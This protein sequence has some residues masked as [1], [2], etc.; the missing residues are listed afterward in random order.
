MRSNED[1]GNL[2]VGHGHDAR[3][4]NDSAAAASDAQPVADLGASATPVSARVSTTA[5]LGVCALLFVAPFDGLQP[6]FEFPGQRVTSVEAALA[7]VLS[8]WVATLVWTRTTPIWRTSLSLPW[9]VLLVAMFVAALAAPAH[10]T[11]AV[12]MVGR[13]GVGFCVFLLT[14]NGVTTPARLRGVLAAAAA[15]GAFISV[16]VALE[17]L[18]V[19]VVTQW[20]QRFREHVTVIGSQVRAG[21]PFQYP[22]IASMY[23]EILFALALPLL[24]MT[25]D[26]GRRSLALILFLFLVLALLA[27][28]IGLTF[29]RAGLLTIASSLAIVGLLRYSRQGFDAGVTAIAAL[30]VAIAVQFLAT[31]PVESVM[32]RMTTEAQQSWYRAVIEPPS[33]IAMRT[34]AVASVPVQVTNAGRS[35]WDPAAGEPFLLSYH[36]LALDDERVVDFEGVRTPFP[37]VVAPG[38][39]VAVHARV[40][41]PNVPGRYRLLWDVVIERRLWFSMAPDAELSFSTV[42]VSGPAVGPPPV[43][44]VA[45]LPRVTPQPGRLTLWRAG[46]RMLIDHPLLGVG[47][48]NFHLI[49]GEYAGLPEFDPRIHTNNMYLEM[50]VAGGIVG[51]LA[52]G[53]LCVRA[54]TEFLR[55]ARRRGPHAAAA[56]GVVAGGAAMGLHGLFDSFLSF[57]CIYVLFSITLGL[58]VAMND[59]G[60]S[61]G[62]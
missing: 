58:A 56:A 21:G 1:T 12:H 40:K 60:W 44:T 9:L 50:L 53:W 20:L 59:P 7:C 3:W 19:V 24:P 6:L 48:D 16:L 54:F 57:T 38:H 31:R 42:S 23:M 13:F 32:L 15:A 14:V 10:R 41:A 47:P 55:C 52:F 17:Y 43:S 61:E 39:T 2:L 30:S 45:T 22:T 4:M 11:N 26:A 33:E 51:G 35:G 34:G 49:Y 27:E 62:R 29:S 28:A 5:W 25:L 8:A 36:W 37:A 46:M 18:D